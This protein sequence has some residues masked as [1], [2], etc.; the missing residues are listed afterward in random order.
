MN[1]QQAIIIGLEVAIVVITLGS[2]VIL[3]WILVMMLQDVFPEA[4]E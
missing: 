4:F 2:A 3:C 1:R